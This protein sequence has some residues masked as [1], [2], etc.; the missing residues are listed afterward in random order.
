MP[1]WKTSHRIGYLKI[2]RNGSHKIKLK[3]FRHIFEE[4]VQ[5]SSGALN[6]S[7]NQIEQSFPIG[8]TPHILKQQMDEVK[9]T[10]IPI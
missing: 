6:K 2:P 7:I 9:Q 10:K 8:Q 3:S 1:K 4:F 5:E